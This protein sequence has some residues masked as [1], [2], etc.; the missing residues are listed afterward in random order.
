MDDVDDAVQL[1]RGDVFAVS[2]L[3][4]S[5]GSEDNTSHQHRIDCW[6]WGAVLDTAAGLP[7]HHTSDASRQELIAFYEDI[8]SNIERRLDDLRAPSQ[9]ED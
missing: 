2:R 7:P 8:R 9:L 4:W 6:H 1:R 3:L 5:L